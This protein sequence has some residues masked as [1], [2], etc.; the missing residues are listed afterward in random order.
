MHVGECLRWKI[1]HRNLWEAYIAAVLAVVFPAEDG[2]ACV[3]GICNSHVSLEIVDD[4]LH[5]LCVEVVGT[6]VELGEGTLEGDGLCISVV[7]NHEHLGFTY[8]SILI[9]GVRLSLGIIH[10]EHAVGAGHELVLLV[11][12]EESHLVGFAL[13]NCRLTVSYFWLDWKADLL[14]PLNTSAGLATSV[15]S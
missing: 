8:E 13:H 15:M 2:V 11:V 6:P 9:G 14:A 10:C 5:A 7:V 12:G 4:S 1:V 3:E